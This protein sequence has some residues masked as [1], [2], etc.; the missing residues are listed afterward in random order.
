[1]AV[2]ISL[3][4]KIQ[5]H[6]IWK[7]SNKL[8]WWIDILLTVNDK[9]NKT[10][11]GNEVF[12][13]KRGDSLLS[14]QSWASRWG[15]SKDTARNFLTLLEKDKMICR[16]SL[17]K[18]TR[19]SVCN[20]DSYN[21]PLHVN[22]TAAVRTHDTNYS[23]VSKDT[24]IDIRREAFKKDIQD[25]IEQYSKD[26]LNAFYTYWREY[27]P[28]KTKMRFELEKTWEIN[29]RLSKW[30]SNDEKKPDFKQ[31]NNYNP[32]VDAPRK[33]IDHKTLPV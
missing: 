27:N 5:D 3:H 15:V 31:Q 23:K 16:V 21:K 28:T 13:C 11:L 7:D 2:F 12:I 1:M 20:Y 24:N 9:D 8:K 10:T 25:Y 26:T 22:R 6:W 33:P 17:G 30:K 19:I 18:S 4:T 29:L 32:T 14:I